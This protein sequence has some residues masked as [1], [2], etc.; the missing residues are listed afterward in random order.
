[1]PQ[2]GISPPRSP[3]LPRVL[4]LLLAA[5]SGHKLSHSENLLGYGPLLAFQRAHTCPTVPPDCCSALQSSAYSM[6]GR[7]WM[8]RQRRDFPEGSPEQGLS[9]HAVSFS[10]LMKHTLHTI[11]HGTPSG[12]PL[13]SCD[14]AGS[15]CSVTAWPSLLSLAHQPLLYHDSPCVKELLTVGFPNA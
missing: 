3:P 9:F 8:L 5:T 6:L 2:S 4:P 14:R 7:G 11:N 15:L 1:M 12:W 13:P 10:V